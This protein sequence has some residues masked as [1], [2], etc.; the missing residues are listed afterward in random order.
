MIAPDLREEA[1]EAEEEEEVEVVR[2]TRR[3]ADEEEEEDYNVEDMSPQSVKGKVVGSKRPRNPFSHDKKTSLRISA[4]RQK[5]SFKET[6]EADFDESLEREKQLFL[7]HEVHRPFS[8]LFVS[9]IIEQRLDQNSL[10]KYHLQLA[11][12]SKQWVIEANC[13][14]LCPLKLQAYKQEQ[15]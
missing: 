3:V 11:D 4:A 8:V 6:E 13:K 15:D 12:D 2:R 7:K 9:F 10:M 1:E 14:A 5:K